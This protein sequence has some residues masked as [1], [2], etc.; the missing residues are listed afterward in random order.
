MT[1]HES[2]LNILIPLLRHELL[3][4]SCGVTKDDVSPDMI[5]KLYKYS[6]AHDLAHVAGKALEDLELIPDDSE[7]LKKFRNKQLLAFYRH[8]RMT[9]EAEQIFET[10]EK[11]KIHRRQP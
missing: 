11:H 5:E 1:E 10:L 7:Y 6:K 9:Y 2:V 4:Q 3:S 8:E